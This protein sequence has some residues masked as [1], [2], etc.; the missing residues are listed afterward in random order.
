MTA[1]RKA[2]GV[3]GI[4]ATVGCASAGSPAASTTQVTPITPP[5]LVDPSSHPTYDVPT[6]MRDIKDIAGKRMEIQ[7][8]VGADGRP[9]PDTF[10]ITGAGNGR[11]EDAVK[12]WLST[13]KFR[14]AMQNGRPVRG[15][16]KMTIETSVTIR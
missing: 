4:L 6:S 5:Q 16:F 15:L 7:M 1:I 2:A 8:W 3:L 11:N 9:E 12:G 13:A 10:R 14:P